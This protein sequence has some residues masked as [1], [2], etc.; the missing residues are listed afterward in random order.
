MYLSNPGSFG[1]IV[2]GTSTAGPS[3]YGNIT[4]GDIHDLVLTR[5]VGT[6][7]LSYYQ[8]GVFLGTDS[9]MTGTLNIPTPLLFG[10]DPEFHDRSWR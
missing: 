7:V 8:N 3:G 10:T 1:F 6:G 2:I 9:G 4:L 5:N